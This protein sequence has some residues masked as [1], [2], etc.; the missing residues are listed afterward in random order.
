RAGLGREAAHQ[1]ETWSAQL[2]AL[3]QKNLHKYLAGSPAIHLDV[4]ERAVPGGW[5]E[6]YPYAPS[7]QHPPKLLPLSRVGE[8]EPKS[9]FVG[10]FQLSPDLIARF[11][12]APRTRVTTSPLLDFGES[13]LLVDG[14]LRPE[15]CTWLV[16]EV[17]R[18]KRVPVGQNGM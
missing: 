11:E 14:L 5:R 15:E 3:H 9:P 16:E 1:F 2:E 18:Q 8:E 10:E 13:A 4:Y 17:A 12:R 7:A 6:E